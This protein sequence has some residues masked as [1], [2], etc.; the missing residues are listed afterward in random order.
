MQQLNNPSN[1]KNWFPSK[2]SIRAMYVEGEI[3]GIL[4]DSIE[5]LM[6]TE[7]SD[8]MV[9][10]VTAGFSKRDF[11]MGWF[12]VPN[13]NPSQVTVQWWMDFKLRWYPWEKFASL[14][15]DKQYGTRLEIGLRR[16][17]DFVESN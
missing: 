6:M 16:L 3:K 9:R 10:A 11:S 4:L 5:A 7:K 13:S 17:K 12:V 1:W 8:S 14:L 15:F 2:D